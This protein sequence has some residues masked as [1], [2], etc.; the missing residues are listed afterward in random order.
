[1]PTK[2]TM[3]DVQ[4]MLFQ[5]EGLRLRVYV[6]TKG[7]RTIG[8]GRNLDDKGITK[9]EATML[10]NNDIADALDD[11]RHCCSVYD[12]LSR[13]RQLVLISMAFNMGRAG[14]NGFIHFL[15]FLHQ[16][17]YNEAADAMLDS[18]AARQLPGRYLVLA[19]MMRHD[20]SEWV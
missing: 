13:P 18:E 19:D 2:G 8:V 20:V 11:V 7:K 4:T 1:M 5:Q 6:D 17:N 12:S 10:L 9:D 14:L 16:G 3:T 15:N